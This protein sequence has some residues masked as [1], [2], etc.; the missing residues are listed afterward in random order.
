MKKEFG[1]EIEKLEMQG[2]DI[3][4]VTHTMQPLLDW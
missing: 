2:D 4:E 1:I 3:E